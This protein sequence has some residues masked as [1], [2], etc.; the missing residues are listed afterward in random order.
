MEQIY[1]MIRERLKKPF[2]LSSGQEL[3][4]TVSVGVAEYPEA[5]QSALEL[6]NCAEIVMFKAKGAGKD[7]M[8]YFDVPILDEF[9]QKIDIENKLKE[10]HDK[11]TQHTLHGCGKKFSEEWGIT[12][13]F[14]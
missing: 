10:A 2:F 14:L 4:I 13:L 3:T 9:L 1:R 12:E 6:I 5:A 11:K 7:S 8:Q